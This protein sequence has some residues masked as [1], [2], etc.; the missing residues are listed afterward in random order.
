MLT[1]QEPSTHLKSIFP[2]DPTIEGFEGLKPIRVQ[3]ALGGFEDESVCQERIRD[4]H[5]RTL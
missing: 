5:A 3:K 1:N 2:K 4:P